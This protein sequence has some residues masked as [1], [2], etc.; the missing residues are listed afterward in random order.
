MNN[1]YRTDFENMRIPTL[2]NIHRGIKHKMEILQQKIAV[3]MEKSSFHDILPRNYTILPIEKCNIED[4]SKL[5]EL[6]EKAFDCHWTLEHKKA[7]E[8]NNLAYYDAEFKLYSFLD[9]LSDPEQ[10][11]FFEKIEG[12]M[13][14]HRVS[15]HMIIQKIMKQPDFLEEVIHV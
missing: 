13:G 14:G 9:I 5:E 7:V 15:T 12:E 1:T 2:E 10:K 4:L 8:K 3:D 6:H 11:R